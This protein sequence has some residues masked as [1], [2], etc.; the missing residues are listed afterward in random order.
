MTRKKPGLYQN[1]VV[2]FYISV[3]TEQNF[4]N[5]SITLGTENRYS[6]IGI[7]S[8]VIYGGYLTI[9]RWRVYGKYGTKSHQHYKRLKSILWLESTCFDRL[10]NHSPGN[11]CWRIYP[12][13]SKLKLHP[14]GLEHILVICTKCK[15]LRN[16]HN[17][18]GCIDMRS[19]AKHL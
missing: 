13:A 18:H 4:N 17:L 10:N 9:H 2:F 14:L 19:P 5:R 11:I 6:Q 1:V 15:A 3:K 16:D 12:L 7:I 8:I